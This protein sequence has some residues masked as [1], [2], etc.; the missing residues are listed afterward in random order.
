MWNVLRS[1]NCYHHPSSLATGEQAIPFL[2]PVLLYFVLDASSLLPW[3]QWTPAHPARSTQE[4]LSLCWPSV[5]LPADAARA[6]EVGL[7]SSAPVCILPHS[8]YLRGRSVLGPA[9]R[10]TLFY[11]SGHPSR[12]VPDRY[13]VHPPVIPEIQ[14]AQSK[15]LPF[16][17]IQT[18]SLAS[19]HLAFCIP[20]GDSIILCNTEKLEV[21]FSMCCLQMTN[22]FCW[23]LGQNASSKM[24]LSENAS[25]RKT[26][27]VVTGWGILWPE[28]KVIFLSSRSLRSSVLYSCLLPSTLAPGVCLNLPAFLGFCS[29]S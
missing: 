14:S 18:S 21:Q 16:G 27:V 24:P 20:V 8:A 13:Q 28:S 17:T 12:S 9:P 10:A 19:L 3:G 7:P 22:V 11:R 5:L 4:R 23:C 1:R 6:D 26:L 25:P 15:D 29:W 2:I